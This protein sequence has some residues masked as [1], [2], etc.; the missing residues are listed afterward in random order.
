MQRRNQENVEIREP[1][2]AALHYLTGFPSGVLDFFLAVVYGIILGTIRRLSKGMLAP[3]VAHVAADI[4][5]FSILVI[6]L[7]Q[8]ANIAIA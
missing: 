1:P 7:F 4:T 6:I 2:F 3:M 8:Y 5:I